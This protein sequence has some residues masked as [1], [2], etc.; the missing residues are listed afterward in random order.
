MAASLAFREVI[1]FYQ[2]V[3]FLATGLLGIRES[4]R[5][6]AAEFDGAPYTA[7]ATA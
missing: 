6:G 5:Y 4:S 1:S 2:S 7:R 3:A